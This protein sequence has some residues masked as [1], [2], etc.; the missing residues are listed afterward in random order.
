MELPEIIEE[1][2]YFSIISQ[3]SILADLEVENLPVDFI[4][5]EALNRIAK[6]DMYTKAF[7]NYDPDR[8]DGYSMSSE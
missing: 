5:D 1:C 6:S 7:I 4:V 3:L 2:I 8:S